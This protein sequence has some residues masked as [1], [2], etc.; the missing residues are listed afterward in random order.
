LVNELGPKC[1]EGDFVIK[2][3]RERERGRDLGVEGPAEDFVQYWLNERHI[4]Q[5]VHRNIVKN[6]QM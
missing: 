5:S 4:L 1:E 2:K 6:V 3:K